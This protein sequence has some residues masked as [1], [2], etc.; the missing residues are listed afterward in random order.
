MA[1]QQEPTREP[2]VC[3]RHGLPMEVVRHAPVWS[4]QAMEPTLYLPVWECA[5][6][7]DCTW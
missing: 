6:G 1:D 2:K 4:M 3:A 5:R 7:R